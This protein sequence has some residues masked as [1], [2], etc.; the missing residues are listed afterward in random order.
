MSK[1]FQ[2]KKWV[3]RSN[4]QIKGIGEKATEKKLKDVYGFYVSGKG[5]MIGQYGR[6]GPRMYNVGRLRT[7]CLGY[8]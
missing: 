7:Q 6:T 2:I 1:G 4:V 3:C 5:G 8:M